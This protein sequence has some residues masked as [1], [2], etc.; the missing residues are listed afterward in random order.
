LLWDAASSKEETIVSRKGAKKQRKPK[1]KKQLIRL[2][3]PQLFVPFNFFAPLRLCGKLI[4][5]SY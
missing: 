2:K 1:G 3:N 4:S 5:Q